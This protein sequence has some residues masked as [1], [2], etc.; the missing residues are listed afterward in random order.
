MTTLSL[1]QILPTPVTERIVDYAADYEPDMPSF[2]P[3]D[4][5]IRLVIRCAESEAKEQ[6]VWQL[7][8]LWV[9][10]ELLMEVSL[11]DI[12]FGHALGIPSRQYDIVCVFPKVR[13]LEFQFTVI[14]SGSNIVVDSLEIRQNISAFV[15]HIGQMVP[16]ACKTFVSLF[17][18]LVSQLYQLAAEITFVVLIRDAFASCSAASVACIYNIKLSDILDYD[19]STPSSLQ[20]SLRYAKAPAHLY[21]KEL[22]I[23]VDVQGVYSGAALKELSRRCFINHA[24]PMVRSIRFYLH[25]PSGTEHQAFI[26][27]TSPDTDSSTST[28]VERIKHMAPMLKNISI[29][30][31]PDD[32]RPH[33][34]A[35]QLN[36]LAAQLSHLAVDI[37]YNIRHQSVILDQKLCRLRRLAYVIFDSNE[38]GEQIMHLARRSASTLQ[39]L[40][41]LLTTNIDTTDLIHNDDGS[42]VHIDA[43]SDPG[44]GIFE[45]DV[46]YTRFVLTI[47]ANAPVRTI[48]DSRIGPGLRSVIPVFGEYTCI[49]VLALENLHLNL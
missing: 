29:L 45:T 4:V 49:Q 33:S 17:D 11:R 34:P 12:Y 9:S 36:I 14:Y 19:R 24:F 27:I 20:T 43:K 26:A 39:F 25:L 3:V 1:F 2:N 41:I 23:S 15:Q 44:L 38:G 10:K 13:S 48:T 46:A 21:A 40:D 32:N 31:S 5:N 7:P 16:M 35:Q 30:L 22:K 28:F 42:Y 47:G 8:L 18:D 6:L 37:A